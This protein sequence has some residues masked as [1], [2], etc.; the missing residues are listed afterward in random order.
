MV[1]VVNKCKIQIIFYNGSHR[2][3]SSNKSFS[4]KA[5]AVVIVN[6]VLKSVLAKL[7][8]VPVNTS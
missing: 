8:T 1:I 6:F 4:I 7:L 3:I 2:G 5:C